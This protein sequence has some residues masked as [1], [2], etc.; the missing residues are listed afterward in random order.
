MIRLCERCFS[1]VA[2]G[3]SFVTLRS[4]YKVEPDGYPRWQNLYLHHYDPATRACQ[5]GTAQM[6]RRN[7][8]EP[9]W[10]RAS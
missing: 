9:D 6:D 3:E 8:A 7:N 1:G 5:V 4:L 2:E 10:H